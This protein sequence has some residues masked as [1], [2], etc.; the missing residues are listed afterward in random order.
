[1]IKITIFEAEFIL[2]KSSKFALKATYSYYVCVKISLEHV[3]IVTLLILLVCFEEEKSF[4]TT[5]PPIHRYARKY[6]SG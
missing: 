6:F 2:E 1:M 4:F 3:L 5:Y